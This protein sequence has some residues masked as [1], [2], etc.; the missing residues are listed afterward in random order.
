MR[1]AV[2]EFIDPQ[3]GDGEGLLGTPVQSFVSV[4]VCPD[5]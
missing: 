2:L 5:V 1:L 4:V 3:Q